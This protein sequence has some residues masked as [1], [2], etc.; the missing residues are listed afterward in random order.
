[1]SSTAATNSLAD[2]TELM[3]KE[4]NKQLGQL[5][6]AA[7]IIRSSVSIDVFVNSADVDAA[8]EQIKEV[9]DQRERGKTL[10]E[11]SFRCTMLASL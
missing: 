3:L 5:V 7:S 6:S 10:L 1:M 2:A 9:S 8:S 11:S 4:H